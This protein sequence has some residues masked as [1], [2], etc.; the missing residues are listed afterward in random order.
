MT[1]SDFSFPQIATGD[2]DIPI[3]VIEMSQSS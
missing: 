1:R 3:A 2:L